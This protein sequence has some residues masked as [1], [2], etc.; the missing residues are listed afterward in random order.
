V[1]IDVDGRFI[2]MRYPYEVNL[3]SDA[4]AALRALIPQLRRKEDR[5]WRQTIEAN[6]ARW[7]ETMEMESKVN[8][9]PINPMRMFSE[10]SPQLPEDAIVTAD[11]GSAANWY[12]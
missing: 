2:G 3:V 5:T 1:Q 8:A 12:A 11:S 7:W 6:V 9:D 10:L 4:K